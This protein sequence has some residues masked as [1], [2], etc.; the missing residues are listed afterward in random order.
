MASGHGQLT[1][2]T[3]REPYFIAMVTIAHVFSVRYERHDDDDHHHHPVV[4][5]D[6]FVALSKAISPDSE[7]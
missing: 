3:V 6:R 2:L 4:S 7:I 1:I 5:C